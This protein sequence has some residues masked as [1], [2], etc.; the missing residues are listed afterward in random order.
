MRLLSGKLNVEPN[1]LGCFNFVPWIANP[2]SFVLTGMGGGSH[3]RETNMKLCRIL[4]IIIIQKV[5]SSK[6]DH[7]N[8]SQQSSSGKVY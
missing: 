7:R 5:F 6:Y 2:D 3:F 4:S 1:L 8:Q